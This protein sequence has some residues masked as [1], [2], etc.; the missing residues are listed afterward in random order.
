MEIEQ[1]SLVEDI[2]LVEEL[3]GSLL[4][5]DLELG[6]ELDQE[7]VPQVPEPKDLQQLGM[8]GISKA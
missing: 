6:L 1:N 2:A 8:A 5:L 4:V 7:Q 3:V